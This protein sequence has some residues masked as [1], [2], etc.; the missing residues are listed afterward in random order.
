M[1]S[2]ALRVPRQA[3]EH[4]ARDARRE[5]RLVPGGRPDAGQ[6]LL[7]R[8]VLEQVAGRPGVE[9]LEDVRALGVGAEHD[10]ADLR[11]RPRGCGAS[12]CARPCRGMERSIS[13]RSG[14]SSATAAMPSSPS[15]A[16]P[17]TLMS[18]VDSSS[19]AMPARTSGWSSTMRTRITAGAPRPA[20]RYR[21]RGCSRSRS[22]PPA[23]SSRSWSARRPKWPSIAPACGS[24]PRP[25]SLTSAHASSGS[26]PTR[27]V[28]WVAPRVRRRVAQALLHRAEQQ[29]LRPAGRVEVRVDRRARSTA[30]ARRR[31]RPARAARVGRPRACR[32]GG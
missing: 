23:S 2:P 5:R 13:T 11:M 16:W 4:L 14:C 1:R 29:R 27:T 32:F 12:L 24:K 10:D 20:A 18:S 7:R 28:T 17:T 26:A 21:A 22:R 9:R 15:A 3:V 6:Q 8:R 31:C 19:W 25:S 30:R